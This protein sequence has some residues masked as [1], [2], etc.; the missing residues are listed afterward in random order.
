MAN[1]IK[2]IRDQVGHQPIILNFAAAFI[3]N[4]QGEILLQERGDG[5]G[6]SLP[7]GAIE[8]GESAE[9][10]M[11]REV[12]EETGLQVKVESFLGVYTRFFNE[13]P[14]G[15]QA[16]SIAIFFIC[17]IESGT[18][19]IDHDETTDLQFFPPEHAP[20]LFNEQSQEA[21]RDFMQGKRGICR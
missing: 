16:Q 5:S 4:E 15:D 13:Y 20:L 19:H 14:N 3:L 17:S 18:L 6:W 7:G 9:D 8:L 1:Y 21:L 12:F 2:W 11:H 10:A